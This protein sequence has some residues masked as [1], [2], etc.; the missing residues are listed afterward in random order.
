VDRIKKIIKP[1]GYVLTALSLLYIVN[2]I[3]HLDLKALQFKNPFM[4][5]LYILLFGVWASLFIVIGAYNWK[6]ILEFVNG[7]SIPTKDVFQVYL[8]TNVAKYLPGNVMH[9]AGRNYLG[10]KLGWKNSEMAFSS[11]LE[12]IFGFGLTGI[13]II[14]CIA[15][16]LVTVPAQA[17]LTI[18][19]NKILA[20]SALAVAGGLVFVIFIYI[21]RYFVSK[22]PLKVTSR[23]LRNRAEQFFTYGF[24]VLFIKLFFISLFCFIMNCLYYFYLCDLVLDFHIKPSDFFNANVALSIANYMSILTPGVPGGLG[25]KESV[26]IL[27]I[28]AYGYPKESLVISILVFRITCVLGDVLPYFLVMLLK[29]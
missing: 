1:I 29:K 28:S 19:Y 17:A 22:E 26:S 14:S 24:L 5:I 2:I 8:K 20:Y 27:L 21:Y 10:S 7:A 25:V 6:L 23:K 13:I 15:I 11:L 18:N 9:Y 12:Y 4:S 3:L 16:G